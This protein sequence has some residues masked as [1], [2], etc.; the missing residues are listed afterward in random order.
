LFR[1]SVFAKIGEFDERVTTRQE[2]DLGLQLYDAGV[3]IVFEPQAR[4]TYHR[5]P[6]VY[7]DERDYFLTRWDLQSGIRSHEV[8]EEK[9]PLKGLPSSV[10]FVRDRSNFVSYSKYITYFMRS[11]LGPYLWYEVGPNM[12]YAI[13]RSTNVLP[14]MLGEPARKALYR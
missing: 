8:I 11:Q 3:R 6:P 2:V 5:P 9:W 1:R 13:Y 12:R 10:P 4:I 14:N 7:R